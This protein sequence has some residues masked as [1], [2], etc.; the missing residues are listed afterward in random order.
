MSYDGKLMTFIAEL[1]P[2]Q[3]AVHVADT[4]SGAIWRVTQPT[5][6][7]IRAWLVQTA[8]SAE[9]WVFDGERQIDRLQ[10]PPEGLGH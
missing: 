9:L 7:W 2:E 6:K 8:G 5:S 4:A 1:T 10:L 3:R